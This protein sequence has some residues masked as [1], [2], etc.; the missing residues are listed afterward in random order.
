MRARD[1]ES[2]QWLAAV[3]NEGTDDQAVPESLEAFV[4]VHYRRLVRL[5][6]IVCADRTDA[7]D[8]VQNAL[9]RA[10]RNRASLRDGGRIKPWLDAIVVRESIRLNGRA[11][12]AIRRITRR[13]A[14]LSE[15]ETAYHQPMPTGLLEELKRLPPAQR[16]AL[17]LHYEGGYQVAEVAELVGAPVETVR[18]RLRLAR[19]RLRRAHTDAQEE[20]S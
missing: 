11:R 19:E 18:S 1:A 5:A 7:Q 8:A 9:E 17:A 15:A 10:W 12:S 20:A 14:G 4:A 3:P 13:L 6:G 16:A 2:T